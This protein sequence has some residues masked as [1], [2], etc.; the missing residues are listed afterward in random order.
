MA[1][2]EELPVVEGY[3]AEKKTISMLKANVLGI[4]LLLFFGALCGLAFHAIWG[5]EELDFS[6]TR[7]RLNNLFFLVGLVTGIVVHELVHGLTW[8]LLTRKGFRHLSFGLMKGGAYCHI[9]VPMVKHHYVIGALMPLFLVG[10]VPLV[11]AFCIG[12][13][14]WLLLGVI[15]VVSAIGDIMIVWAIRKEPADALVYDHPTEGGCFVY[16]QISK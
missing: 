11:V 7:F 8:I 4:V 6:S 13:L 15:F 10:I 9:D 2:V 14:L 3:E 12:S 16:H 1:K 5:I